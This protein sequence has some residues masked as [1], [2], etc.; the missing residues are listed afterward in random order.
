MTAL[1]VLGLAACANESAIDSAAPAVKVATPRLVVLGFDGVDPRRVDALVGKG[2]LPNLTALGARGY[3]GALRS[4]NPPQ[5][6][7]AWATFATGTQAGTHGIYDFV[8]RNPATYFPE[9]ATTRVRHAEVSGG[10][11]APAEAENLRKGDAFWDVIAR[12]GIRARALRVPYNY[13]LPANGA[14]ALAG[15]GAPDVRG[16][17]SSFTL[18]T[19]DAAKTSGSPPAGGQHA[20]LEP[21]GADGFRAM[22]EGPTIKVEGAR[23]K[24]Y[25]PVTV[26]RAKGRVSVECAGARHDLGVGETSPYAAVEFVPAPGL[27]IRGVTRFTLRALEPLEVYTEPLSLVPEAPYLGIA[28]PMSFGIDLWKTLGPTKTVGWVDDTSGLSAGAMS[29]T[30]FLREAFS[31]MK[32]EEQA[33]LAALREGTDRVLISVFTSPDRIGHMFYRYFDPAHPAREPK[34]DPAL[35]RSLDD[36]YLEMDRI[37]GEVQKLLAPEDVLLVISDHGFASFRR[38]FNINTWLQKEG[39]LTL[40]PGVKTPR[41]FF[42][43][44]DWAR[45][46]AYAL[47]TGSIYVNLRGREAHGAV[48]PA[49]A[50]EVAQTIRQKLLAARDGKQRPVLAAYLADDVY[51]G[52]A[53]GDAPDVR[54]ALADGYRASWA[55]SLGGCPKELFED[56]ARKWSGDHASM[57]PEDVPGIL[58]ASRAPVVA[59]PGIEDVAAT[60]YRFVGV[61]PPAGVA[62]RPW[63]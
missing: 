47:G 40:K 48:D 35:V 52:P 31:T 17:N 56:N 27:H 28:N 13:P 3:R 18:L 6:P 24:T 42:A 32:W 8:G 37:V 19:T 58:V 39:F 21:L 57:R 62:G 53:R 63:F 41:D 9:I 25:T 7:V 15:L 1:V 10:E 12:E 45:T 30:Q 22:I 20:L 55:T 34:P 60:V 16:I 59:D 23:Q 49:H 5:S 38:G 61:S 43:D 26:T 2:R 11:V 51:G 33:T 54:V 29:E 46:R 4:T 50:A 44:V 14:K 36:A